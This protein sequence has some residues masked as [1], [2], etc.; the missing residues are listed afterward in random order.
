M[1]LYDSGSAGNATSQSPAEL[2]GYTV[3]GSEVTV[4][5]QV[6]ISISI[7]PIEI[8]IVGMVFG[9][10]RLVHR[11]P[12]NSAPPRTSIEKPRQ[13]SL[14]YLQ[15]K[16]ELEDEQRRKHELHGENLAYELNSQG[17]IFQMPDETES[18]VLPVQRRQ[19]IHGMPRG[20]RMCWELPLHNRQEVM[21]HEHAQELES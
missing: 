9:I 6:I 10:H 19:V 17:E 8:I 1:S 13:S 11:R 2:S 4:L 12:P 15:P 20:N 5:A 14:P 21:G 7:I 16:A 18:L 3:S